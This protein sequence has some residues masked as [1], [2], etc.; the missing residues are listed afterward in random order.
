[1]QQPRVPVPR[2][3][4]PDP[5][6]EVFDLQDLR[7][8]FRRSSAHQMMQ[9][10]KR[11]IAREDFPA[12]LPGYK[13]K[14]WSAARVRAWIE[15]PDAAA[16]RALAMDRRYDDTPPAEALARVRER[17]EARYRRAA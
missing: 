7:R 1:M 9:T 11:W 15:A 13:P 8:I 16:R 5:G 10:L 3:S 6:T 17:L 4:S 12:P 2:V 14:L